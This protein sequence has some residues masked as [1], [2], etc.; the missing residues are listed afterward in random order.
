MMTAARAFWWTTQIIYL[1]IHVKTAVVDPPK[2]NEAEQGRDN[3]GLVILSL[4]S[5][6]N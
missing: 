2:T 6:L 1:S 3:P 4:L 5:F